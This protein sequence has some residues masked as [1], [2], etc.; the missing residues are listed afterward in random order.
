MDKGSIT[1]TVLLI[2][3]LINQGLTMTGH[4]V[5]P[6]DEEAVKQVISYGFLGGTSLWAWWK[7]NFIT[8]KGKEQKAALE[9]KG[10]K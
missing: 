1:R 4:S 5:I 6:V 2:L 3:A 9:E 7:N 10:L 8:H